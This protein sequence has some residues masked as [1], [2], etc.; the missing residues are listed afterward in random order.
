M[1]RAKLKQL[2][3]KSLP[4]VLMGL[5]A[6]KLSQAWR[7][8]S[9]ANFS[10]KF[11]HLGEG[12]SEAFQN[13][14]PSF[15]IGDILFGIACGCFLCLIVY[16]KGRNAKKYRHNVEYGSARWGTSKDI[17]PFIDPDPW[18]NVILTKTER[19]TINGRPKDPRNAHNKNVMVV[20]GSG[21]GKT[22]FFIKPNIMQCT[23]TK[24]TSLVVTDPKG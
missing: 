20:G 2:F 19:M 17:A 18:N 21:S 5:P 15:Y 13:P 11:L 3:L 12:F 23:K 16:E 7:L 8:S 10:E 24:G 4:Y 22:R 1:N 9:G 6:T 14:L